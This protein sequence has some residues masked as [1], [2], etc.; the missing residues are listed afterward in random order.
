MEKLSFITTKSDSIINLLIEKGFAYNYINKLLRNKDIKID[1]KPIKENIVV[2]K[3]KEITIFY[4]PKQNINLPKIEIIYED[5]N[6]LIINKPKGIEVEGEHGLTTLF[7]ALA[8]HRLDRN[9]TGLMILAKNKVAQNVLLKSFKNHDITKKYIT[10]VA[11]KV[12]FKNKIFKAYLLKDSKNGVVKIFDKQIQGSKEIITIFNTIKIL[13]ESSLIE[14]CL[15]TGR[16]H[17]IRASLAYLGY[18]IIGDSKY[19]RNEINRK[20]KEKSQKLHCFYLKI[21]KLDK[22]LNYLSGKEFI[23]KQL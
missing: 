12:N 2:E 9:T 16:T 11:G 10:E 13:Q 15:V 8:V 20:F 4:Q 3:G 1:K 14:C 21:N 5:E 17:Q 23:N 22:P 18:P 7:N 6:V 19:G